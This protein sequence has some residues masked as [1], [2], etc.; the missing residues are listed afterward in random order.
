MLNTLKSF[1]KT[2]NRKRLVGTNPVLDIDPAR[3]QK[4]EL[5]Y[6]TEEEFERLVEAITSPLIRLFVTTLYR[7]GMRVSE[8]TGLAMADV[9]LGAHVIHVIAG[10]GNKN[11]DVPIADVL[12]PQLKRYRDQHRADAQPW[13]R[14][15]AT[16]TTGALSA[17]YVNHALKRATARAAISKKITPH[18]LRHSFASQLVKNGINIVYLQKLLGH[19]NLATTSIYTHARMED[20]V[21]AV[22]TL[23]Q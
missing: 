22:N 10:K 21:N 4:K 13:Q 2:M 15:F 8:A 20:L 19:S 14:F 16:E 11:R 5:V 3:E 12:H 17:D 23:S 7:T 9:D 1:Y 18:T 6:I